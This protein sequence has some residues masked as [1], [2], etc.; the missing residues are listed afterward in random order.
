MV[1]TVHDASIYE[2]EKDFNE[3]IR[4]VTVCD[5]KMTLGSN[6]DLKVIIQLQNGLEIGI[7]SKSEHVLKNVA[8]MSRFSWILEI[9]RYVSVRIYMLHCRIHILIQI[10]I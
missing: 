5:Y 3:L 8:K 4:V 2:E 10:S 1:T 6:I 9:D 7:F